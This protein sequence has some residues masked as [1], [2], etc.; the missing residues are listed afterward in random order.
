MSHFRPIF[1]LATVLSAM[2]ILAMSS[3]G[4]SVDFKLFSYPNKQVFIVAG[5]LSLSTSIF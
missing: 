2:T 1:A 5:A 3:C 4:G